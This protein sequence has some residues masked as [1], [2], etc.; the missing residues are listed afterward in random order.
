MKHL[1]AILLLVWPLTKAEAQSAPATQPAQLHVVPLWTMRVCGPGY[2]ATYDLEGARLLRLL[3]VNCT[4]WKTTNTLLEKKVIGYE[5]IFAA[6]ARVIE[7]D[8]ADRELANKRI[9]D[10]L[11]QLKQEIK[12]K[13]DY[14][15]KPSY[16]WVGWV[17]AGGLALAATGV[18]VGMVA[19]K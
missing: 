14:K 1:F 4:F 9:D 5:A 18:V 8:K 3:D 15:Y 19:A 7:T 17:V 11:K 2:Y 12:E 13:N 6:Q 16:A 10:L